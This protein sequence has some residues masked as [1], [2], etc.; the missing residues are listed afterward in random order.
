[1]QVSLKYQSPTNVFVDFVSLFH[2]SGSWSRAT[3]EGSHLAQ[4]S[5]ILARSNGVCL[6]VFPRLVCLLRVQPGPQ[7]PPSF[8]VISPARP[9]SRK[10]RNPVVYEAGGGEAGLRRTRNTLLHVIR[11]ANN[12]ALSLVPVAVT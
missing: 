1:M 8:H 7:P 3:V 11:R 9:A 4:L 2:K 6:R 10:G 5:S 12:P